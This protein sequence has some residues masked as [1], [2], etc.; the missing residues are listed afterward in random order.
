MCTCLFLYNK[1]RERGNM[2][3]QEGI[4]GIQSVQSLDQVYDP[5]LILDTSLYVGER[6]KIP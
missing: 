4:N 3:I 2:Y 1:V 5:I 6:N